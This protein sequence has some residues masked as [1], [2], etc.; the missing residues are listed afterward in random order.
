M[1]YLL[2]LLIIFKILFQ[3]T[4]V[5]V[6][7]SYLCDYGIILVVFLLMPRC[8]LLMFTYALYFKWWRQIYFVSHEIAKRERIID[9]CSY[10]IRYYNIKG[11][12]SSESNRNTLS[13]PSLISSPTHPRIRL[14]N[15]VKAI[16]RVWKSC[17]VQ[18]PNS[19]KILFFFSV[20]LAK[21]N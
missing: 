14:V 7:F 17:L 9:Y 16:L 10:T 4:Y 5:Q 20:A 2:F 3:Q 13:S 21:K 1:I 12:T 18:I 15:C 19:C 11:I 8:N 6:F